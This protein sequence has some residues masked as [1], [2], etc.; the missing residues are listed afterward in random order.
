MRVLVTGGAGFIGSHLTEKLIRENY[1]VLVVDNL[2]TIGGIPF[3]NPKSKFIKGDLIDKKI[4]KKI[5][6]WKPKI[7]FHLAAQSGGESAYDNPKY[8][9]MSN[10]FATHEL[11]ELS[12]KIKLKHFI[13]ASS[14][15]V[16]G[17]NPKKKINEKSP[18]N[19]DSIYGVSKFAGEMFVKQVLKNTTVKTTILRIFNTYGPGENLNYFKKGMVSIYC[20]YIWKK[21]PIIVKGSLDRVRDITFIDDVIKV[22]MQT[23]KNTKLKKNEIINLSS[24]QSFTVKELLKEIILASGNSKYK[25]I[26]RGG[27]PG[28]SKLFHTSNSKLKERYPGIQFT[29]IKDGLKKYFNWINQV[30]NKK[31]L[32]K[33]HPF[34]ILNS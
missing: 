14:V 3:I 9:F 5:E 18:I 16:Y 4:L 20:G 17:S 15:A 10:G 11:C 34:K 2:K 27:T 25:I 26:V 24:G 22:L 6:K 19:P 21:K 13:Y 7:I 30:P 23:I 28:D 8:D 31:N 29:S 1:K 12:K 32:K 33:F